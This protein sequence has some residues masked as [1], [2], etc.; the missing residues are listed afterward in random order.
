MASTAIVLFTRDLR[1]RDNPTLWHAVHD[2]D[3][4]V[5]LFV[6]DDA[7]LSG[8]YN[9][10][11][12]ATFLAQSLADLDASLRK[13]GGGLVIRRGRLERQVA[14]VAEAVKAQAVHVSVDASGY[15]AG[16]MKRLERVVDAELVGHDDTLFVVPPG[17][18]QAERRRRPHERF[19]CVLPAVGPGEQAAGART[20]RARSTCR[21][22]RGAG[23]HRPRTSAP[24]SARRTS[25]R[26][27]RQPAGSG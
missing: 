20:R 8:S 21:A 7:I 17:R 5:P 11:N 25:P 10:P 12:R 13:L 9:R 1:V 6:L 18:L 23:C 22:S 19:R 14:E 16:R 4:I 27:A 2:H 15:S 26:A 24:A 3:R